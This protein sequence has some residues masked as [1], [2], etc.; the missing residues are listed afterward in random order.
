MVYGV[1]LFDSHGVE[2]ISTF[3]PVF[4]VDYITSPASGNRMYTAIR[5]KSLKVYPLGYL[6]FGEVFGTP[7]P[8]FRIDGN[9]VT[10]SGV[11]SQVPLM[12]VFE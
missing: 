11:S 2:L 3:S 8:E 10:W 9:T 5:G 6:G 12:V 7:P 4:I 1:Q